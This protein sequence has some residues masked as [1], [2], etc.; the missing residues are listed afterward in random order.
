MAVPL[1]LA[2]SL[3]K[4]FASAVLWLLKY[5]ARFSGDGGAGGLLGTCSR[6]VPR[7][8]C[9]YAVAIA[10][11]IARFARAQNRLSPILSNKAS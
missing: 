1:R 9:R 7:P 6:H 5:L 4:H 10:S 11:R 8:R 2:L 3:K